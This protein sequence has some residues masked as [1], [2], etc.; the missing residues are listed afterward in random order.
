MLISFTYKK[1]PLYN[2]PYKEKNIIY[3]CIPIKYK[4]CSY[5]LTLFDNLEGVLLDEE[6]VVSIYVNKKRR[7]IKTINNIKDLYKNEINLGDSF[8]DS[9]TSLLFINFQDISIEYVELDSYVVSSLLMQEYKNENVQVS[10]FNNYV[11]I[12]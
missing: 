12:P 2:S 5:I 6:V 4:R 3:S 9:H 8:Y 7:I 11:L 1:H 10:Y